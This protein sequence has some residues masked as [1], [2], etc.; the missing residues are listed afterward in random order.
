M[1]D[2]AR[3][4]VP[5]RAQLGEFRRDGLR[6]GWRSQLAVEPNESAIGQRLDAFLRQMKP[7]YRV[8]RSGRARREQFHSLRGRGEGIK[9]SRPP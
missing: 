2:V 8:Q 3:L 7:T 1:R 6:V 9:R 5:W 4:L